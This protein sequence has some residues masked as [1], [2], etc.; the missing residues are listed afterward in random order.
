MQHKFSRFSQH[1]VT[2]S[3]EGTDKGISADYDDMI[4][5]DD[6]D[7]RVTNSSKGRKRSPVGDRPPKKILKRVEIERLMDDNRESVQAIA[8]PED[9][10][11]FKLLQKFGYCPSQGGLG[12][13]CTGLAIPIAMNKRTLNNRAGL[14]VEEQKKKL[15]DE[16]VK[17]KKEVVKVREEMIHNFKSGLIHFHEEQI[18]ARHLRN[19]SKVIFELDFR[20]G[21]IENYLWPT[22]ISHEDSLDPVDVSATG[23]DEEKIVRLRQSLLYLKEKY[24]Y[25]I[26]CGFQYESS[27]DFLQGCPGPSEDDH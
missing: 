7:L 12:K 5:S 11:G 27:D 22:D 23:Y 4:F 25:C 20:S 24:N 14:G 21:V 3:E 6:V 1:A 26:F 15:A 10:R 17:V 8:I 13:L 2:S 19:A 9:N 16:E 18:S